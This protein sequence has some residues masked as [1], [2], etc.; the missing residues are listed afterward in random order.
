MVCLHLHILPPHTHTLWI[1]IQCGSLQEIFK[2]PKAS[3]L[4]HLPLSFPLVF[5][6]TCPTLP[7]AAA[8][9]PVLYARE[10]LE[11]LLPAPARL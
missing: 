7:A 2:V 6:G 9:S 10:A 1:A 4:L 8:F 5:K 11:L 3:E